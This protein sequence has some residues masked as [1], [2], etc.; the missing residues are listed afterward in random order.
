MMKSGVF[1]SGT[2]T[3]VGKTLVSSLILSAL[4]KNKIQSGYFK[5]IQTGSDLDSPT[6]A[7][8]VGVH[9][10]EFPRPIY[11]FQAPQAPS[12]AAQ[13]EGKEIQLDSIVQ[14]W[15][16]L[17][18]QH[19]IVEGAGGLLVP[20]NSKQTIRDLVKALGLRLVLVSS[21]R[22]GTINHT[23]LSLEAA[24]SANIDVAGIVLVGDPDPGLEESLSDFS[25][26]PILAGIPLFQSVSAELVQE[27]GAEF[28]TK[29]IL[30]SLFQ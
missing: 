19:W 25:D 10:E 24:K 20:L 28:F 18:N 17:E 6:V 27:K 3:G 13:A 5:P 2:D 11:Q 8:R 26:T 14:G 21:T 1:V 15:Q 16:C 29:K 23:L 4:R 9:L 7:A 12:R 30:N 22:L